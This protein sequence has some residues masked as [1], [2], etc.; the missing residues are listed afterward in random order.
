MSRR[1]FLSRA[2]LAATGLA[3]G[4]RD[5]DAFGSAME[6]R[7]VPRPG[8]PQYVVHVRPIT[9]NPDGK[10]NVAAITAND[11]FPGLEIRA[12]V[13]DGDLLRIRVTRNKDGEE[14]PLLD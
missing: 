8:K 12:R 1:V 11:I 14:C 9:L 2:A 7:Y 4:F 3:V 6:T 5:L 10:Q 13:G